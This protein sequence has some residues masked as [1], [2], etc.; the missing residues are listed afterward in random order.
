[1]SDAEKHLKMAKELRE[2]AR[3]ESNPYTQH[4][5][6]S[7]AQ[8]YSVLAQRALEGEGAGASKMNSDVDARGLQQQILQH[9]AV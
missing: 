4:D 1:M 8:I 9:F 5:I 3:S 6:E 7:A 2:Q